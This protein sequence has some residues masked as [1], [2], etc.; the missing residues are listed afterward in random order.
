MGAERDTTVSLLG[1]DLRVYFV[2][3]VGVLDCIID[4]LLDGILD[5]VIHSVLGGTAAGSA[6]CTLIA[7]SVM[8][9][10]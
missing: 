6:R 8:T 7:P 2:V 5:T 9:L 3:L 4:S 1:L 10:G